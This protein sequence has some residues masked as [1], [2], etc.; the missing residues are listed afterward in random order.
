MMFKHVYSF[1]IRAMKSLACDS[2]LFSIIWHGK[3]WVVYTVIL[4]H[5]KL[6][7]CDELTTEAGSSIH[8]PQFY[9][10]SRETPNRPLDIMFERMMIKGN[11]L[12]RAIIIP[13]NTW[14]FLWPTI[15]QLHLKYTLAL[16]SLQLS[17]S[18][19]Y[20]LLNKCI[21]TNSSKTAAVVSLAPTPPPLTCYS[22]FTCQYLK[23]GG[24]YPS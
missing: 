18:C 22:S 17:L 6:L 23:E 2:L 11:T 24:K 21:F 19:F 7:H 16:Q 12:Y 10:L 15:I 1:C 13:W 4:A 14:E 9:M 20:I 5:L 8:W 3:T